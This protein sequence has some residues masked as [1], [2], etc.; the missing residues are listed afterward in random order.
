MFLKS[1]LEV[2]NKAQFAGLISTGAVFTFG[3]SFTNPEADVGSISRF[4]QIDYNRK[5]SISIL[6]VIT[7]K[8]N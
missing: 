8:L 7:L 3:S 5:I 1:F 4:R 2:K 6:I